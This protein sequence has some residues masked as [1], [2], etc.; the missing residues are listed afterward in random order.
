MAERFD[1]ST[2]SAERKATLHIRGRTATTYFNHA[3]HPVSILSH[4][5]IKI[6]SRTGCGRL[7]STLLGDP[8]WFL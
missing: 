6:M 5:R 2:N 3:E 1:N 7:E 4:W 8:V